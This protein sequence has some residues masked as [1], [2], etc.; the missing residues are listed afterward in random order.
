MEKTHYFTCGR[1][2]NSPG[3]PWIFLQV[4]KRKEPNLITY[5]SVGTSGTGAI[6]R[7]HMEERFKV[8]RGVAVYKASELGLKQCTEGTYHCRIIII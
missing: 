5:V 3:L 6:Q 7:P 2:T 1:G 8:E 4:S